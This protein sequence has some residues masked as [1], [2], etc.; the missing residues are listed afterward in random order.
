M[1]NLFQQLATLQELFL[2]KGV[3]LDD[4][5]NRHDELECMQQ[6]PEII[7]ESKRKIYALHDSRQELFAR[8]DATKSAIILQATRS[9]EFCLLDLKADSKIE[10]FSAQLEIRK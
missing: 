8:I 7:G 3:M 2:L 5:F 1:E 4:E 6:S 10:V 9:F